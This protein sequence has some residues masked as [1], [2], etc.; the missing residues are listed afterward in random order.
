MAATGKAKYFS[1]VSSTSALDTQ[2]FVELSD[3]LISEG[4]AGIPEA[5]DLQGSAYGLGSGYGQSKW[6]AE[7][8]IRRAG[9]RGLKGAIIRPGYVTGETNTGSSNTDDFLL[10]MLKG[11]AELGKYPNINNTINMVPVDHVARV[12]VASALHPPKSDELAVVQVTGHPRITFIQ[13]VG[14]LKKFGYEIELEDYVSWKSSLE[15]FVVEGTKES[16]LYPLL[17]FVLDDLPQDTKA[18]ELDDRNAVTSLKKD[19]EWTGVDASAGRGIDE[20][21][22]RVYV[23]YLIK[24]GFLPRPTSIGEPLP[25]ITLSQEQFELVTSGAGSRG[26]SN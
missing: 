5:D 9:E 6:A 24:V 14:A 26:S 13:F 23:A 2:H 20:A 1:F 12:V 3:K 16:A 18:P 15:K 7:Y 22:L 17:H 21:Q 8:I 19:A 11:C 10:R 4:K 25:E